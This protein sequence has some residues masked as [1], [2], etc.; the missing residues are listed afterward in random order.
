M[1]AQLAEAYFLRVLGE[2][3]DPAVTDSISG[4]RYLKLCGLSTS[5]FALGS[6]R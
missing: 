4:W 2:M 3:P 1:N 5:C 6:R